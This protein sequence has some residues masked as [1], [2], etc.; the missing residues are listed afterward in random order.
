MADLRPTHV[1]EK[2]DVAEHTE[3][4]SPKVLASEA[5]SAAEA[6]RQMTLW[7]AIK[8]YPHAIGW[9]I[10]L[11]ST[12][13]MEGYDLALLGNLYASTP[14]N[15]KYGRWVESSQRYEIS[16]AWQSALSNGARAGEI[17]GLIIAGWAADRWGA[18]KTTIGFLV[19]MIITIFALFFAPN[20]EVLVLGEILCGIP[21]GA[22]QGVTPAYASEVTPMVLRPYLTTFINACWVIGQLLAAAVN[23]GAIDYGD[24]RSYRIPFGVQWIWPVLILCGLV[25]APESP[26]WHV[27]KG[28]RD[29]A[30]DSLLRLT[31]CKQ[32]GF[33]VEET[34]A[35]IEHT[36]EM[37]KQAKEG[38]TYHDCFRGVDIRRTE[39]VVGLGIVQTL[40]GQNLMGYYSYFLRQAGMDERNAFS[41]SIANS[42]LG[43]VGTCGSWALMTW[44]GRRRIH[45][46]G[47]CGQ[48]LILVIVGSISF[49]MSNTSVWATAGMLILFTFVYD[50]AVGPVTY[51]LVSELS[52]TRLKAK[53]IVMARAGY[54]LSNIFVNVMTNYQLSSAAWNWGSRTAYFWAGTC[55]LCVVWVFFRLPEPKGRTYAELDLLFEQRVPARKFAKTTV[56]PYT[57]EAT[58]GKES[59]RKS[60]TGSE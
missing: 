25:F 5:K 19:L 30:R 60:E 39:I 11:S 59:I 54:N 15:Q 1:T 3:T 8:T 27:R 51:C 20:V 58:D 4:I 47:L 2:V 45:F 56:N 32:T 24:E 42:A 14:F 10:L 41:L 26:W 9:S 23:R 29:A 21:W 48:L 17:F 35:M 31:S 50:F 44:F 57:T 22:F 12:I 49:A 16:P 33:N 13:I 38:V 18:K 36:N 34:L 37:E 40:G 52:S 28:N 53:T 7:T 55:F 46:S 6:E 43:L